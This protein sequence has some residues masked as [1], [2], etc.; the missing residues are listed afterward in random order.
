MA[1]IDSVKARERLP[2][3]ANN[4]VWVKRTV[5]R[6]IGYRKTS[7]EHGVW[8]ARARDV[9]T[10]KQHYQQLGEFGDATPGERFKL[11][12]A[13]ADEWFTSFD[14]GVL[15]GGKITVRQVC[16][17]HIEALRAADGEKKAAAEEARF[18]RLVYPDAL[19]KLPLAKL[20]PDHIAAWKARVKALP[21]KVTRGKGTEGQVTKVRAASTINRDTVPLR[22]ALNRA[23]DRGLVAT[24]RAWRVELRP[25]ENADGRREIYLDAKDRRTLLEKA[26]PEIAPFLRGMTQLPLRPGALAGLT[27]GDFNARLFTLRVGVDKAGRERRIQVPKATAEFLTIQGK[28]KLP[29]APLLGRPDGRA[30]DKDSWKLPIKDAVLAA[31]LP[32]GASAYSLRH[33]VITD[34][35]V[36]GLDLLTCAQIAGTSVA[37]IEKYY[38]HLRQHHAAQALE[39]LAL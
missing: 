11:A 37:M 4:I 31:G 34:L 5:G 39:K 26:S 21:A 3:D 36:G 6:F 10:G 12:A 32:S 15:D 9:D 28:G 27:V 16:E 19:A 24:D 22:A 38:G 25:I 1:A 14:A 7:A 35:V 20:R 33:S 18:T 8:W 13:A 30:W 29:A 17:Q 2:V 23:L